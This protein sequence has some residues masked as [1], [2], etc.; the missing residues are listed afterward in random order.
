MGQEKDMKR[1][2]LRNYYTP[3]EV[4][5]LAGVSMFAVYQQINRGTLPSRKVGRRRY[6]SVRQ[7]HKYASKY[8]VEVGLLHSWWP[9]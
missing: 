1:I 6:V 3:E 5:E 2:W 7:T 9:F 4:S 8:G